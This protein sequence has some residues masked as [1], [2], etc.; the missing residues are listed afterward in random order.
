MQSDY[1]DEGDAM[2]RPN[3]VHWSLCGFLRERGYSHGFS[4]LTR[5]H[6][7]GTG[8]WLSLSDELRTGLAMLTS[9]SVSFRSF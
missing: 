5:M 8:Q 7:A 9:G 6:V 4:V 2:Q 3:A 1:S